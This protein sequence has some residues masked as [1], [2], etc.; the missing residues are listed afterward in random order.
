MPH[1][2]KKNTQNAK[3]IIEYMIPR[4]GGVREK[5]ILLKKRVKYIF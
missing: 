5:K 4:R 1:K 3:T 2:E